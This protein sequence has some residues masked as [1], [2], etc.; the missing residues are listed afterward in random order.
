MALKTLTAAA[1]TALAA[2]GLAACSSSSSPSTAASAPQAAATAS[3]SSPSTSAPSTPKDGLV[4]SPVSATAH[5]RNFEEPGSAGCYVNGAQAGSFYYFSADDVTVYGKDGG[6]W[7]Q[8]P[9]G[10]SL[11]AIGEA[12][13][14]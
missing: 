14:C 7:Q 4:G 8:G 6:T 10:M 13:G 5:F 2:L 12:L 11:S 1:L 9:A 3:T